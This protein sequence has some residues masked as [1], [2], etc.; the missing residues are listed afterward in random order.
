MFVEG[1][2]ETFDSSE[3]EG[4]GVVEL[5][6][7]GSD[8]PPQPA[9]AK[10]KS[11]IDDPRDMAGRD[12]RVVLDT[13]LTFDEALPHYGTRHGVLP[14]ADAAVAVSSPLLWADALDLMLGRV[15]ASGL[16]VS[17]LAAIAGSAQQ[18]GSVYLMAGAA[19][20]GALDSTR[21]PGSQIAPLLSRAVAP[22]WL[23]SLSESHQ[24][25]PD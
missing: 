11:A 5:G 8:C 4:A 22:I 20:F 1:A 18:H 10:T 7:G 13:S 2:G 19:G 21:A 9:L 23:D 25:S 6:T 15:A 17:R 24:R 3:A 14:S 12:A 16:D